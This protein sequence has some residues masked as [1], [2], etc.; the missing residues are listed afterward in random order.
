MLM[1]LQILKVVNLNVGT[2]FMNFRNIILFRYLSTALGFVH[3]NFF[4]AYKGM[5]LISI[6]LNIIRAQVSKQVSTVVAREHS[7]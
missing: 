1:I 7:K 6:I 4:Q 2:L 3:C 5:S